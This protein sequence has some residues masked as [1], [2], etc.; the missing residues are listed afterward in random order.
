[1]NTLR[2]YTNFVNDYSLNHN[3]STIIY[4]LIL[5]LAKKYKDIQGFNASEV[6]EIVCG[7]LD[8]ALIN[9]R[10]IIHD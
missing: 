4:N 3:E 5:T 2:L 7:D 9:L 1:M 10:N 8:D 6:E